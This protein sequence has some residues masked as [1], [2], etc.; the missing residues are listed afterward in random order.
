M[1]ELASDS[2]RGSTSPRRGLAS[3]LIA[4]VIALSLVPLLLVGAIAVFAVL[5]LADQADREVK[6]SG[7]RLADDVVATQLQGEAASIITEIE[8]FLDERIGDAADLAAT[9]EVVAAAEQGATQASADGLVGLDAA[10]A[11]ARVPN[12]SLEVDPQLDA[13][14][15]S[16]VQD[17]A[18]IG[19]ILITTS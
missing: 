14:L 7:D 8:R 2:A 11:E 17:S 6:E 15:A 10:T 12:H 19:S 9:T 5:S 3:K 4:R 16:R 1:D 18:F 13:A